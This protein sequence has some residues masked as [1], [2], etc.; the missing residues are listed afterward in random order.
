MN[1]PSRRADPAWIKLARVRL[2]VPRSP[3]SRTGESTPAYWR[4]RSRASIIARSAVMVDAR[5]LAL[6]AGQEARLRPGRASGPLAE[7]E[8]GQR[9]GEEPRVAHGQDHE[10][11]RAPRGHHR[12]RREEEAAA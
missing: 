6:A 3:S 5:D 2:P 4:A 7:A 11:D 8:R 1:G 10:G 9:G 12:P